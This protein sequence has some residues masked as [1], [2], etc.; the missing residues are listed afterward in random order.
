V[1]IASSNAAAMPEVIGDTGL[2]FDPDDADDMAQT[3]ERLLDDP[4]LRVKLG[5]AASARSRSFT[6]EDTA[7]RTLDVLRSA[8]GH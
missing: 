1:P 8:A 4:D 5:A 3:I 6:W 7:R 2:L